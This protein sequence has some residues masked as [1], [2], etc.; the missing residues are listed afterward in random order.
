MEQDTRSE[1]G[2]EQSWI[3]PTLIQ[4]IRPAAN[5]ASKLGILPNFYRISYDRDF[6]DPRYN[7]EENRRLVD[8]WK[9]TVNA[10]IGFIT[11]HVISEKGNETKISQMGMS[12]WR[13]DGWIHPA[14]VHCQV[15]QG[16]A[17]SESSSLRLI[18]GDFMCGDTE[19][20]PESDVGP[21]LDATFRSFQINQDSTCLV[22]HDIHHILHLIQPYWRVP[23]NVI[24]LDTRA[25]WESQAHATQHPSLKQTLAR[26]ARHIDERLLNNAGNVARWILELLQSQAYHSK[27]KDNPTKGGR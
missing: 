2:S 26:V 10:N 15:E 19:V 12:K 3:Y 21:W 20:I 24:I 13:S 17:M 9:Q 7:E 6:I 25:I 5:L 18:A 16:L 14:S 1:T 27:A 22:G 8:V 11:L 4:T 23:S